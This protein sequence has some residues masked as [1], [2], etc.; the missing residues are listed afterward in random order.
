[1]AMIQLVCVVLAILFCVFFAS[2]GSAADRIV[3]PSASGNVV[4]P[5]KQHQEFIKNCKVCHKTEP[6]TIKESGQYRPH[7]LCIGCHEK[8]KSGPINCVDCHK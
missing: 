5:H 6:G 7:K 1:M 8:E 2:S 4:F 3:L